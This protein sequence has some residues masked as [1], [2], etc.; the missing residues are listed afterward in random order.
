MTE[1]R[2]STSA[3]KLGIILHGGILYEHFKLA[4]SC[5]VQKTGNSVYGVSGVPVDNADYSSKIRC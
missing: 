3:F 4:F 5:R 1:N 2:R